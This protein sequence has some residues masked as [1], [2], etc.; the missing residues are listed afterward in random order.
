MYFYV[1]IQLLAEFPAGRNP[2]TN[3]NDVTSDGLVTSREQLGENASTTVPQELTN[4]KQGTV[5]TRIPTVIPETAA[6]TTSG[7]QKSSPPSPPIPPPSHRYRATTTATTTTT[8]NHHHQ[9]SR[10]GVG[11]NRSARV[12]KCKAP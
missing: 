7:N 11:M 8:T 4:T 1:F 3:T 5:S 10:N 12:V 2:W 9:R 6:G